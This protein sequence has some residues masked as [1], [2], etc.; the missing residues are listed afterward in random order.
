[1]AANEHFPSSGNLAKAAA[2]IH[3]TGKQKFAQS[4]TN[5]INKLTSLLIA[6]IATSGWSVSA[7]DADHDEWDISKLDATKL[8]P[9]ATAKGLT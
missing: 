8:P 3:R 7:A 2:A 4:S 9:A 6:G 5:R 1:L